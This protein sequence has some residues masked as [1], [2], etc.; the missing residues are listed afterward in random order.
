MIGLQRCC[1]VFVLLV[2]C[3]A[4]AGPDDR[5]AWDTSY[6]S[7][8]ETLNGAVGSSETRLESGPNGDV[9]IT[10]DLRDGKS[11]TKGTILLISG[12][13]MMTRGLKFYPGM[14]IDLL[15]QAALNS[16]LVVS[17]LR[18]AL[19]NGPPGAGEPKTVSFT[20]VNKPIS[21]STTSA[22]GEY[23]APWSV[24]GTIGVPAAGALAKYS[25]KF[26]YSGETG[27]VTM[28]ITGEVGSPKL[29]L[30]IP[31][32]MSLVGWKIH[33]LGP[34]QAQGPNSAQLDYGAQPSTQNDA[35]VGSLRQSSR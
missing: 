12:R 27:K 19:P 13:W 9:R 32:S 11:R 8:T 10:I 17:L 30:T 20:E 2:G 21:V 28:L 34:T 26:T 31:D 35:T 18:A 22:S 33:K 4:V 3:R 16:Q 1:L 15:D 29:P 14:E 24:N 7:A 5:T 23:G 25:L 6:V